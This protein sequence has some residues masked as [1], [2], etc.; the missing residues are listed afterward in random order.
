MNIS[1]D[2][3]QLLRVA[4]LG[5]RQS[6]EAV[7]TPPGELPAAASREAQVL[8]TA[9]ALSLVRKAGVVPLAA[10]PPAPAGPEAWPPLGPAGAHCLQQ[11]L[12][13]RRFSFFAGRYLPQVVARQRRI[14]HYLLPAVF[15]HDMLR[16]DLKGA[17]AAAGARG[18]WLAALN[19]AWQ[20]ILAPE[21]ADPDPADWE[22]ANRHRRQHLVRWL[23]RTQPEQLRQ[24]LA[25]A[26]PTEAAAEQAAL[27]HEL[28]WTVSA[29]DVP[30]LEPYL[31]SG[32]KEVRQTVA[33][34]L[35]RMPDSPLLSRLWDL[36]APLLTLAPT[37]TG[38]LQVHLPEPEAWH[39]DWQ[40][41]GIEAKDKRFE[42]GE[43]SGWLGQMLA[44]LPPG[45]WSAHWQ[46]TPA[47]LLRRAADS[48]WA[49]LLRTAWTQAAHLHRDVAWAQ[50]LLTEHA[51]QA[52]LTPKQAKE[53]LSVLPLAQKNDFLR[54]LLPPRRAITP[55]ALQTL[56]LA[57]WKYWPRELTEAVLELVGAAHTT[58]GLP[59]QPPWPQ[60]QQMLYN[61]QAYADEADFDCC[62]AR[63]TPLTEVYGPLNAGIQDTL[64]ALDFRRQLTLSLDEPP[65]SD[66]P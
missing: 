20:G 14:P 21:F 61:L 34:L 59:G 32:S 29:A 43:R 17:G 25:A 35:A 12:D 48:E 8:L 54:E 33:A 44:L 52:F 51:G 57:A 13:N 42:G 7:P 64:A 37:A 53:L 30:L 47:E 4:L 10:T 38:G 27:L 28:R 56:Q 36:A 55:A 24:L 26:L 3:Q 16:I 45:R 46:Q 6:G 18:Q 23:H 65:G 11:M 58:P 63:L 22:T 31:R 62:A 49:K 41:A 39:K 40:L 19:P 66:E 15:E 9:G 50:A 1:S 60:L 5:T 2:W